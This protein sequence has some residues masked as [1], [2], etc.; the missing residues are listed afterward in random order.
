VHGAYKT[1]DLSPFNF[2]R[3][4]ANRPIIEKAII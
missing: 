3:I 1:L 4:A 2:D